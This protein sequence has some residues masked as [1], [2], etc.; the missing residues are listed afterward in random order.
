MIICLLQLIL[1]Q[2]SE[3]KDVTCRDLE[4]NLKGSSA[5]GKS[6][7]AEQIFQQTLA[8]KKDNNQVTTLTVYQCKQKKNVYILTTLDTSVMIDTI[9]TKKTETVIFYN[10]TKCGMILLTRWHDNT[11]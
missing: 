10:K 2:S 9:T 6:F 8:N 11:R 3:K 4:Q 1:R 7:T 5:L